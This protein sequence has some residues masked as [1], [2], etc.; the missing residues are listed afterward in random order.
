MLLG[1][2]R[3]GRVSGMAREAGRRK[4]I[5]SHQIVSRSPPLD[6]NA[7][8]VSTQ[9]QTST[10]RGR[11]TPGRDLEGGARRDDNSIDSRT[12]TL[13]NFHEGTRGPSV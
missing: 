13:R 3:K 6:K 2:R 12:H 5:N 1:L 11:T 7:R 8:L 4:G 10:E 9:G